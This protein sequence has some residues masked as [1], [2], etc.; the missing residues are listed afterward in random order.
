MLTKNNRM[1]SAARRRHPMLIDRLWLAVGRDVPIAFHVID[2]LWRAV[3]RDV[4]IA[5]HV[6]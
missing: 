5:F 2:R 3:A 6:C 4:P 1:L